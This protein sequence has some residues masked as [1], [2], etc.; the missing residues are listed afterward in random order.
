MSFLLSSSSCFV[1]FSFT[2]KT[3]VF[4]AKE[5][6]SAFSQLHESGIFSR[7]NNSSAGQSNS[8]RFMEPECSLLC[9][10]QYAICPYPEPDDSIRNLPS[11]CLKIRLISPSNLSPVFLY[12]LVADKKICFGYHLTWD[13]AM[14][15][16]ISVHVHNS[17]S[18]REGRCAFKERRR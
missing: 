2:R 18:G 3:S 17:A 10:Q 8:P 12:L 1:L 14:E 6:I 11:Q 7:S 9:S 4:R 16:V 5:L 13:L 15:H